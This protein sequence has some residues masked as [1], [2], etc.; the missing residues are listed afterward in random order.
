[1]SSEGVLRQTQAETRLS[2]LDEL[3]AFALEDFF[4]EVG[5][6][7]SSDVDGSRRTWICWNVP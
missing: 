5:D 6:G 7:E 1:M 2:P 3:E 4:E